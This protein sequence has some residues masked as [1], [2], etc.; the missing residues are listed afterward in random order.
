MLKLT[1]SFLLIF[2]FVNIS[3]SEFHVW[4]AEISPTHPF[5][6]VCK[7]LLIHLQAE[8]C[9]DH[10]HCCYEGT[11]CDLVHAKCV[12]KT[13][14]L[15]WMR[16]VPTKQALLIPQVVCQVENVPFAFSRCLLSL[17][18]SL[19]LCMDFDLFVD[20]CTKINVALSLSSRL[21]FS[22]LHPSDT[23]TI[24]S[25]APTLYYLSLLLSNTKNMQNKLCYWIVLKDRQHVTDQCKVQMKHKGQ[26]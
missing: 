7:H 2:P 4:S 6:L 19:D 16:R 5:L 17:L 25:P 15:P 9:S 24:R 3:A 22:E 20:L 12:N 1:T 10:L 21:L 13:V 23:N 18:R 8:C 11:V 14:S 26:V